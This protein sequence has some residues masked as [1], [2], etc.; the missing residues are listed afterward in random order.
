MRG[1]NI[2]QC[3]SLWYYIVNGGSIEIHLGDGGICRVCM[4]WVGGRGEASGESK[5]NELNQMGVEWGMV[6]TLGIFSLPLLLMPN[7]KG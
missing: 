4:Q 1:R 3:L 6:T 5:K 2:V 7:S